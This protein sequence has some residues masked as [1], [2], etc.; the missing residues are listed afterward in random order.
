MLMLALLA[1]VLPVQGVALVAMGMRGPAHYH[2]API[3]DDE[4]EH[5]HTH[6]HAGTEHHHHHAEDESVILADD[7]DDHHPL[8]SMEEGASRQAAV[9]A[10]EA[11]P[12]HVVKVPVSVVALALTGANAA[13]PAQGFAGRIDRPPDAARLA[14][15]L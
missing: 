14:A 5:A 2:V 1:L 9:N 6:I 7:D 4:H 11:L 12:S 8:E 10:C 13:K 3:V 15:T